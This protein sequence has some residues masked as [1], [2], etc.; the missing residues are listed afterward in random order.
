MY[1]KSKRRYWL[2]TKLSG[3]HTT[4]EHSQ[5]G[6]ASLAL[7]S[8]T[9][10]SLTPRC[11]AVGNGRETPSCGRDSSASTHASAKIKPPALERV[12][13]AALAKG[14]PAWGH[15]LAAE[16]AACSLRLCRREISPVTAANIIQTADCISTVF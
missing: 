8:P 9:L 16:A 5:T 7:W 6:G 3:D 14:K 12:A 13:Q 10:Q 15:R 2:L 1:G 11:Q 4:T